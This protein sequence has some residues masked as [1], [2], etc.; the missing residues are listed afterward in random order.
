[1]VTTWKVVAL[2]VSGVTTVAI[3]TGGPVAAQAGPPEHPLRCTITGTPGRD[4]LRGTP[5]NDTICGLGGNDLIIG[6]DGDDILIGGPGDDTLLGGRGHDVLIGGLGDD[7]L[8]DVSGP[9]RE[10]GG[11]GHDICVGS[12][13]APFVGCDVVTVI[14]HGWSRGR[15]TMHQHPAQGD[16]VHP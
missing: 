8:I 15:A 2:A 1:M 12:P 6:G 3:V 16:H 9:S 5:G 7:T 4:V 14:P 11:P 13:A 10:D